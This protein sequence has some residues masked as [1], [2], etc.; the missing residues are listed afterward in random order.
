MTGTS[1]PAGAPA[2]KPQGELVNRS[3]PL[4]YSAS[5]VLAGALLYVGSVSLWDI[6][7]HPV[8]SAGRIAQGILDELAPLLGSIVSGFL[9]VAAVWTFQNWRSRQ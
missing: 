8:L 9:L 1:S 7:S 4:A 3:K 2:A 5:A 6:F